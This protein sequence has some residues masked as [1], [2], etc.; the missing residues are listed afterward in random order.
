[1]V[2][3]LENDFYIY[4]IK[5]TKAMFLDILIFVVITFSLILHFYIIFLIL[6]N[7]P[8]LIQ[9]QPIK[10]DLKRNFYSFI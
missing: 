7:G 4:S 5:N 2:Y 3:Y 1:M 6:V 8:D 10:L 9:I